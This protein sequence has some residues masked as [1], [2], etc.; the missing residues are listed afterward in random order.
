MNER[1]I[2]CSIRQMFGA[3][4]DRAEGGTFCVDRNVQ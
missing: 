4:N 1:M 2:F 3:D